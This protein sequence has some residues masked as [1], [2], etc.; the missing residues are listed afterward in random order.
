GGSSVGLNLRATQLD[1]E[2]VR[3]NLRLQ[4]LKGG[5]RAPQQVM[6]LPV[7]AERF[8]PRC[9]DQAPSHVVRLAD[10]FKEAQA[11]VRVGCSTIWSIS[12]WRPSFHC[13]DRKS[14]V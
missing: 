5:Q 10:A 13:P 7:A 12:S 14:V 4:T 3:V 9:V 8:H 11:R 2:L 6:W 1:S